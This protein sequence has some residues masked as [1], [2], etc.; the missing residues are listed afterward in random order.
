LRNSRYSLNIEASI[1]FW[2]P[3]GR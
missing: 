2:I 3:A 1:S